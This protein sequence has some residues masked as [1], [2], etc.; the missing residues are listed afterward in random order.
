MSHLYARISV[1]WQFISCMV[2]NLSFC[3]QRTIQ[4]YISD[5]PK[6]ICPFWN[7][8]WSNVSFLKCL[9]L[10][11]SINKLQSV[12]LET[13]DGL[14]F[15]LNRFFLSPSLNRWQF[16]ETDPF[17]PLECLPFL[18]IFTLKDSHRQTWT[19]PNQTSKIALSPISNLYLTDKLARQ[20]P[21]A[22]FG[23]LAFSS[24][25]ENQP[26]PTRPCGRR[27]N[28]FNLLQLEIFKRYKQKSLHNLWCA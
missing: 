2:E 22:K 1:V 19:R 12:P 13:Q 21:A 15:R 10:R 6:N 28:C 16:T 17:L 14:F 11:S 24:K 26:T 20:R 27:G 9:Y 7:C 8:Y 4:K 25:K 5:W 3:R 18:P 23:N